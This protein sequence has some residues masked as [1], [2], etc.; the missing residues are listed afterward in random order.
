LFPA[1]IG[2]AP[3]HL[4]SVESDGDT[5]L[6]VMLRRNDNE[7]VIMLLNAGANV[8]AIGD[9]SETPL[10]VAVRQR[11]FVAAEALLRAGADPDALSEFGE[12]PRAMAS[13]LAPKLCS[14]F[15]T[16]AKR[17]P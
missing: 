1:G 15:V 16:K 7:A 14:L 6:H 13:K 11:N 2:R 8:N 17:R 9:M 4:N 12:T 5:P 10:H 3:V